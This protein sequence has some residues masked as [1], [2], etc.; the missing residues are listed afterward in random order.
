MVNGSA[1]E[2]VSVHLDLDLPYTYILAPHH[3]LLVSEYNGP[4]I[5]SLL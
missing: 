3:P 1:A 4:Y 2:S 5:L